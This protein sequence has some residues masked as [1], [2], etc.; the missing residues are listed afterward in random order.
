MTTLMLQFLAVRAGTAPEPMMVGRG[1]ISTEYD[2]NGPT[3]SW[4][5]S[6]VFVRSCPG[7]LI[8]KTILCEA[9]VTGSHWMAPTVLPFSG[10]YYD[11][12]PQFSPDRKHLTFSSLRERGKGFSIWQV[13]RSG[14]TWGAPRKLEAPINDQGDQLS[15][16]E[17]STGNLYVASTRRGQGELF[18]FKSKDARYE[19]PVP[20]DAVNAVGYVADACVAPD[21]TYIIFT[22]IGGKD[23]FDAHGALY[24]RSDLYITFQQKGTWQ[25]PIHLPRPINTEATEANPTLS[26]DGRNLF[27]SSDRGFMSKNLHNSVTY[28]EILD[29]IHTDHNGLGKIFKLKMADVLKIASLSI[30]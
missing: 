7:T 8:T 26:A 27:F 9:R 1:V 19:A 5:G 16:S 14:A 25:T 30:K 29:N 11:Q 20:I 23:E 4:D 18:F 22:A 2:V 13:E 12:N 10:I 3:E 24:Q 15:A 28:R 6:M 17:S 21:E